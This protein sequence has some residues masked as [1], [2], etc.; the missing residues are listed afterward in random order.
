MGGLGPRGVAGE[1]AFLLEAGEASAASRHDLV[2]IS[3]VAGIEQQDVLWGVE[4]PVQG[5]GELDD[6]EV[7]TE[8]PSGTR[9]G[10]HDEVAD[11]SRELVALNE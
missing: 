1:P 9:H 4:N 10:L 7:R 8:M 11:L 6:A 3:L 5:Q 2:D